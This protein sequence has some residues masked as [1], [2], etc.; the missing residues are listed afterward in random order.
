ME[1]PEFPTTGVSSCADLYALPLVQA[2]LGASLHPGGLALTREA[3]RP[4]ELSGNFRLLDVACGPGASALML[5]QV[6]ECRVTGVDLNGSAIREARHKACRYRLT[7]LADFVECNAVR[8]PFA[9]SSFDGALCECAANLFQDR[10]SALMEMARVLKPG[11]SLVLTDVTFRPEVLPDSLDQSLARMLCLPLGRGP[12]TLSDEIS[13][14]GF[15]VQEKMDFSSSITDLLSKLAA[16]LGRA[17]P[18][19]DQH[20]NG[21][22]PDTVA[23]AIYSASR[24]VEEGSLGYWGFT[25]SAPGGSRENQ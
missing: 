20:F 12:E 6:H 9:S 16:F 3:V 13:W 7:G 15:Q 11:A 23:G 5:A 4:L 19:T 22:T 10:K 2:V 8:L 25:A 17:F 21:E 1:K 18:P 14:A 24:L